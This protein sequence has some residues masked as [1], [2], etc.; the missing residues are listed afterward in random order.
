[1]RTSAQKRMQELYSLA[2]TG[3]IGLSLKYGGLLPWIFLLT[4]KGNIIRNMYL[5]TALVNFPPQ[6]KNHSVVPIP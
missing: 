1:M 2:L 4:G 5:N 3:E 6:E